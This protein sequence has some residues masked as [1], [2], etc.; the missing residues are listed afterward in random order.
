LGLLHATYLL[1]GLKSRS[2]GYPPVDETVSDSKEAVTDVRNTTN[3]RSRTREQTVIGSRQQ[4]IE[5]ARHDV[6]M[7]RAAARRLQSITE[8]IELLT[9]RRAD[10]W[11]DL[12]EDPSTTTAAQIKALS[13]RIN[14]L[15]SEARATRAC[16]RNGERRF[17]LERAKS[18]IRVT[19][20]A[21]G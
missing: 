15:W 16:V 14:S 20:S 19:R 17:I 18:E 21:V 1:R 3:L 6:V 12:A 11:A 4:A 7:R 13:D 10:A 5:R 2:T 8:E 9:E